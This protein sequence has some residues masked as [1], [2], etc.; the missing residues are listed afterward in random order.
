M[1]SL[2]SKKKSLTFVLVIF[3]LIVISFTKKT[4]LAINYQVTGNASGEYALP[5]TTATG[6]A[7]LTGVYNSDK[8]QLVY[9]L[10]WTGL[11]GHIVVA[12]FYGPALEG[13]LAAPLLEIAIKSKSNS[14]SAGGTFS[15]ADS[16]EEHLLAGKVYYTLHTVKHVKGEVRA[17]VK[18]VAL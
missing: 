3:Y 18:L 16:T 13:T 2:L 17:Q 6:K 1:K 8:N 11:T 7:T 9:M 4:S 12:N 10:N 15:V 5:P 14:G